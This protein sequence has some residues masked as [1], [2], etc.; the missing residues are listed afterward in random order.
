[1]SSQNDTSENIYGCGCIDEAGLMN[2]ALSQGITP[3]NAVSEILAN[4]VDAINK[5]ER[6]G[7][8][9]IK[10]NCEFITFIDDG[11]GMN[12]ANIKNFAS[13][14]KSNNSENNTI[15]RSGY[16]KVSSL[17]LSNK[18]PVIYLTRKKEGTYYKVEIP[19]DKMF[20]ENLY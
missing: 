19:W 6:K 14:Y 2:S 10:T 17:I 3:E 8:I 16:G 9:Q 4:S 15:G 18:T 20:E 7:T 13:L 5:D 11:C 1:M 12:E